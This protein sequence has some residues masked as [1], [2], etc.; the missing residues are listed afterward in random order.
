MVERSPGSFRQLE[1]LE[2]IG[3]PSKAAFADFTSQ[4]Y[5]K[6]RDFNSQYYDLL[7]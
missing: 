7:C 3:T 2:H 4:G 1:R 5:A 6:F